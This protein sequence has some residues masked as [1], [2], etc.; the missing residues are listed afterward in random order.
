MPMIKELTTEYLL[1]NTRENNKKLKQEIDKYK[2]TL[3]EIRETSKQC[4]AKDLCS[5]DCD[6]ADRCC[7]EDAE[8]PTY[9]ICKLIIEKISEVLNDRN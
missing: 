4:M 8:V 5:I 9:D 1:Y 7:I 6:Y 2:Q 3:E